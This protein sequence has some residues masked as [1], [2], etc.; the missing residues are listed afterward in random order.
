MEGLNLKSFKWGG[1]DGCGLPIEMGWESLTSKGVQWGWVGWVL[2]AFEMG[3][4]GSLHFKSLPMGL[5]WMGAAC[6]WE[7]MGG[8]P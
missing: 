8:K 7:G 3:W 6:L 5:D 4:V 2:L 1:W